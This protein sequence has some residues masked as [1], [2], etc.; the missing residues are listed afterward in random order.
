MAIRA[1]NVE[2]FDSVAGGITGAVIRIYY[3]NG[4]NEDQGADTRSNN[5]AGGSATITNPNGTTST[6][7]CPSGTVPVIV[8]G[9]GELNLGAQTIAKIVGAN[10]AVGGNYTKVTCEDR[11]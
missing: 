11:R 6:V 4:P 1:L 2:K 7:T 10:G 5:G 9:G 3:I 8:N